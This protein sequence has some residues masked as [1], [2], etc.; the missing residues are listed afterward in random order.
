M[1]DTHAVELVAL[2]DVL[3]LGE[4]DLVCNSW[5]GSAALNLAALYPTRVRRV[6]VTG[7]MPVLHGAT[8]PL[9][10]QGARGRI[11]R[12]EYF[13]GSGPSLEKMRMLMAGLEWFDPALIPE[14]TVA[15]RYEQSIAGDEIAI[16][17]EP[18]RRGVPQDLSHRLASI[19]ATTLVCWGRY[20]AFLGPDY[21]LMVSM[22]IPRGRLYVMENCGHHLQE[23]RPRVYHQVVSG[24]LDEDRS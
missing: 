20:D 14:E 5:G 12:D 3:E 6:V 9:P 8:T 10:D 7:A 24:F 15:L 1:W 16:Y 23:E 21:A 18:A 19:E 22:M 11:A 17:N 4:V 2:F 13:G